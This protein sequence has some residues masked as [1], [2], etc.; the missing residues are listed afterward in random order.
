MNMWFTVEVLDERTGS[1]SVDR[2]HVV[3]SKMVKQGGLFGRMRPIIEPVD[4]LN[5][6]FLAHELASIQKNTRIVE[7]FTND[8]WNDRQTIV[9]RDKW[10]VTMNPDA[11]VIE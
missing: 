11:S 4:I 10:L 5:A 6:R 9:W 8:F 1:W 3:K 7:H 2:T